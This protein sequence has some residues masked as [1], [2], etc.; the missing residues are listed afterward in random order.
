MMTNF[1]EMPPM[2]KLLTGS[3]VVV[4]LF[5]LMSVLPNHAMMVMGRPMNPSRPTEHRRPRWWA[6][7]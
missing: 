3:V 7:S 2:L 4:P 6:L 1:T 5:I